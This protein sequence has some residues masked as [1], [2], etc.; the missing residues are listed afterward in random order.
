MFLRTNVKD[1]GRK[2]IEGILYL[3]CLNVDGVDV[4][5]IGVTTRKID[6]RVCEILHSHYKVYRWFPECYPKR[7]RKTKDVYE[8]E[9]ILLDYFELYKFNAKKPF[10]GCQELV[11]APLELV[12]EIY[13][14]VLN[15]E[16]LE[17]SIRIPSETDDIYSNDGRRPSSVQRTG[18]NFGDEDG[19]SRLDV[20]ERGMEDTQV[21]EENSRE[22][23]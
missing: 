4:V 20:A 1:Y 5:K 8:K 7:F 21:Q 2:N 3:L 13:E 19:G 16:E 9:K 18:K 6:D 15:G 10:G 22:S 17:E 12:V 23:D 14:K 11:Y